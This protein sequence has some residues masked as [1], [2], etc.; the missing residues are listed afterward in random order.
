MTDKPE[1]Y[2]PSLKKLAKSRK[3]KGK[4]IGSGGSN[5]THSASD[6]NGMAKL[7]SQGIYD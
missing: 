6:G 5:M 7:K 1:M 3:V 4:N 2:K